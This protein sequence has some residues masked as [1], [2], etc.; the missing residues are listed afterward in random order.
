MTVST[1]LWV[2]GFGLMMVSFAFLFGHSEEPDHPRITVEPWW[3]EDD[4][5]APQA[6]PRD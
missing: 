2:L 1:L 5:K 4:R 3:P 6:R